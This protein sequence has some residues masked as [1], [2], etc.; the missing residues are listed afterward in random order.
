MLIAQIFNPVA[1]LLFILVMAVLAVVMLG[2]LALLVWAIV[3]FVRCH[4][5]TGVG[6]L[7]A[8]LAVWSAIPATTGVYYVVSHSTHTVRMVTGDASCPAPARVLLQVSGAAAQV[9]TFLSVGSAL[10]TIGFLIANRLRGAMFALRVLGIAWLVGLMALWAVD[11]TVHNL[12]LAGG[13]RYYVQPWAAWRWLA[14]LLGVGWVWL[15]VQLMPRGVGES[16]V[17]DA[18]EPPHDPS[19]DEW[20]KM[21]AM[22][23]GESA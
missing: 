18:P 1:L 10:A 16:V 17:Q 19:P 14:L 15:S 20:R 21:Q 3:M 9:A 22:D 13:R 4:A 8:A 5:A 12:E 6:L 7:L 2:G 23:V 11:V